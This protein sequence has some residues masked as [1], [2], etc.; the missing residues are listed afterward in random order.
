[1]TDA[2]KITIEVVV[3]ATPAEAWTA[4]TA[5]EAIVQWNQASPDWHCPSAKVDLR[6]GGRHV[7]R[8]EARD[9]SFGFD[10][11]ATYEEVDAPNAVT[12]LLDDGRRARTTFEP[13]GAGA[14]VR[15]VFDPEATNPAQMQRDGWKAI[16]NSYAAYVK[17]TV[18]RS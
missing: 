17:R 15:T 5:P 8:M 6:A 7:A 14:R 3:D 12:L 13:H 18:V 11:S 16:L 9:G 4:Y 1:M 10:F 2:N